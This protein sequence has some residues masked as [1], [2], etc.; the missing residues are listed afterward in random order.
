MNKSCKRNFKLIWLS[1]QKL[2]TLWELRIW[3]S[4]TS[5]M[6]EEEVAFQMG[7]AQESKLHL[8]WVWLKVTTKGSITGSNIWRRRSWVREKRATKRISNKDICR[9][10][11]PRDLKDYGRA[12]ALRLTHLHKKLLTQIVLTPLKHNNLTKIR[13][14]STISILIQAGH[15][16]RQVLS[17]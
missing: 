6:I 15:W 11:H 5:W 1:S 16:I 7:A 9:I 2:A 14:I 12:L 17:K 4:K 13:L 10:R 3:T 8:K